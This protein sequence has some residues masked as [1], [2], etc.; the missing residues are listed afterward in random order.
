VKRS[1]DDDDVIKSL[2]TNWMLEPQGLAPGHWANFAT[3]CKFLQG[4]SSSCEIKLH[5]FKLWNK[6]STPSS[7][8]KFR[9]AKLKSVECWPLVSHLMLKS[10]NGRW[11][12]LFFSFISSSV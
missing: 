8:G 2:I 3:D 11:R 1:P 10:G 6:T 7:C 12:C 9:M 4:T 5:T